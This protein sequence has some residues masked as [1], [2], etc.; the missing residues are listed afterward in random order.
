M[1]KHIYF[2]VIALLLSSFILSNAQTK[3]PAAK[4]ESLFNGKNLNGW[5]QKT[6]SAGYTV[7]NGMIVGT[8]VVKSPNSFLVTDKEYGDF[9]MELDIKVA[10]TTSNSGV[11]TR[12]HFD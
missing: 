12:S 2:P 9:I 4:W 6:G 3:K 5:S 7:E 8:T 11:Q 1:K 10:D